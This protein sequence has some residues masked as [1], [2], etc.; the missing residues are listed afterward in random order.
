MATSLRTL[1]FGWFLP[2]AGDTITYGSRVG[3]VQPS[4]DLFE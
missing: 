1:E 3:T 4:M 2:T